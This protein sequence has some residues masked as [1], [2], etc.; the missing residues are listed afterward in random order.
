MGIY[1]IFVLQV[2]VVV[3]QEISEFLYMLL[4]LD[5]VVGLTEYIYEGYSE[6]KLCLA[7]NKTSN[8]KKYYIQKNTYV[9]KLLISVVTAGIEAFVISGNK[10]LYPC[11]KEVCCL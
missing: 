10:F 3:K 2:T 9:L 1:M 6:S 7:V 4:F 11:V 8:G 5:L